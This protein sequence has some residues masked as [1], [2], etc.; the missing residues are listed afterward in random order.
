MVNSKVIDM[1]DVFN[2]GG[3][4]LVCPGQGKGGGGLSGKSKAIP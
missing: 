4:L 1:S 3:W 2:G